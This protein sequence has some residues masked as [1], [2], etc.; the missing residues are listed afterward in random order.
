MQYLSY[1]YSNLFR[2]WSG[3]CGVLYFSSC[4]CRNY[5]GITQALSLY[6]FAALQIPMGGLSFARLAEMPSSQCRCADA[7]NLTKDV[8][9]DI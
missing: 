3:R 1:S 5:A 7:Q 6:L 2:E 8:E 4:S 9:R